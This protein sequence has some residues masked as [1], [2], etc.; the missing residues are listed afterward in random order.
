MLFQNTE[1]QRSLALMVTAVLYATAVLLDSFWLSSTE[2][3][4]VSVPEEDETLRTV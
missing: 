1:W 3:T 4:V 2:D